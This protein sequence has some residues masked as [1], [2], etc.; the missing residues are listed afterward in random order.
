MNNFLD[1]T[2]DKINNLSDTKLNE[3]KKAFFN[4]MN[5]AYYLFGKFA[6]RKCLEKDFEKGARKPLINKSIFT[7]FS[8]VLSK[9]DYEIVKTLNHK[10]TFQN[11]YRKD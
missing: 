9:Y 1:E 6:F 4:A 2:I 8:Y 7:T 10:E 5:N 11:C 3:I